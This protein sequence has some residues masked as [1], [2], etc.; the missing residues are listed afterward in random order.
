[1]STPAYINHE[2]L[3]WARKRAGLSV[4]QLAKD[5]NV[6]T[7]NVEA[8]EHGQQKPSFGKAGDLAKRLRIPFGYLFLSEP[9][10]DDIPLPDLRTETGE[11]PENPSLDFTDLVQNT[12]LKQQ[13]YSDYLRESHDA[14]LKFVGTAQVG[15]SIRDTADEMRRWLGVNQ[16]MRDRCSSWEKFKVEF[17]RNVEEIGVLVMRSGVAGSNRRPLS[18]HEF[19]GFA[20]VDLIAPLVFI[21]A[22]DA[23]SAQ[24]FTLAHELVHIWLG[25]SGVSN[26]DPQ[27]RSTDELN[28]IEQFCNRVAAELLVPSVAVSQMWDKKLTLDQNVRRL[29][30]IYR[31]SRYVVARQVYEL[32]KITRDQYLVYLDSYKG[33]W[34]PKDRDEEESEGNF[35]NTFAARNSKTLIAGVVRA[36]GEHRLTY[37][38][39][40]RLLGIKI[41]TFKKV[42]DRLG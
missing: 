5:L 24:I 13:W 3:E 23:K 10:A 12:L 15:A 18:V 31:V 34:K 40:S 14:K 35:Y 20:I 9:P 37:L 27:K 29:V 1:M 16:Q 22:R 6:N 33:L 30:R 38:D 4:S 21:N 32:D 28:V 39:A 17:I 19:R 26:P 8:W 41:A 11:R 7:V 36:L 2:V 42:A 25:E